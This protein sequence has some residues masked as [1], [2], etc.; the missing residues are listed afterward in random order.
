MIYFIRT[1]SDPPY[2]KIGYTKHSP[3]ER[4]GAL[5]IGCPYKLSV[6]SFIRNAGRGKEAEIHDKLK[7]YQVR[8]EWFRVPQDTIDT[9]L[10][11]NGIDM[12]SQIITQ[13]P[14]AAR[15]N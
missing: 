14:I 2:Y 7:K 11:E 6:Y 1:E 9:I 10:S 4:L 12:K 3:L 5:Q 13:P 8:G 15:T